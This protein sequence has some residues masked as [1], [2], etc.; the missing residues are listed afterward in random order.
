[1]TG[2]SKLKIICILDIMR[3]TDE[4]HPLNTT[5]IAKELLS[6]GVKAE[7]KSIVRDLECLESAGYSIMKCENHNQGWYMSDQEFEEYELKMLVDAVACAKFMTLEESRILIKKLKKLATKEGEKLIDATIIMDPALKIVDGKFKLKYDLVMRAITEKKQIRFQYY[8]LTSG[9]K[10]IYKRNGYVYQI[11][12]Y[13]LAL[14]GDEYFVLGNPITHDHVTH[15]RIEM[16]ANVEIIDRRIRPMKEIIELKE[17]GVSK[18]IGE[19]I[20]ENVNMWTGTSTMVRLRCM[21][22]CRHDLMV[23]FGKDIIMTDS[24]PDEFVVNVNVTNNEGFYQWLAAHGPQIV[25]ESPK[26]MRQHY[27]EYLKQTLENYQ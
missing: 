22:G 11:S 26:D 7:R 1:M 10:K 23:K 9:N 8:E 5:Q 14:V 12:P 15:F 17:I 16:M 3:K 6:Y 2:N 27:I 13:Y 19:Y 25:L 24:G 4:F 20:R 18:T 21:N